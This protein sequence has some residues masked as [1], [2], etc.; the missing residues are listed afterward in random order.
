MPQLISDGSVVVD[1]WLLLPKEFDATAALPAGKSIV[2]LDMWLARRDELADTPTL[3]VWLDSD[4]HP[5]TIADDV[6]RFDVIAI[7]FP[8]F[9]DGRGYSYARLLR[10]RYGYAGELRAIGDVLRD[11]LFY[12]RR[13]GFNALAIRADRD[14]H[15]AVRALS[16]FSDAYQGAVDQPLPLFRRRFAS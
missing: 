8:A 10:E 4:Q 16:D 7:N 5:E 13:C 14:I 3:G 11:Q 1:D 9:K 15:D 2:P 12:L 6:D